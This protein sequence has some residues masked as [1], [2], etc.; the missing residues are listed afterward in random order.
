MTIEWSQPKLPE[1]FPTVEE[2]KAYAATNSHLHDVPADTLAELYKYRKETFPEALF[3]IRNQ[4]LTEVKESYTHKEV[5]TILD[6]TMTSV[7]NLLQPHRGDTPFDE[8]FR[9][10]NVVNCPFAQD[11]QT[12]IDRNEATIGFNAMD[13]WKLVN[14]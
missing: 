6:S 1:L 2:F 10:K 12:V 9:V 3:A 7:I 4:H 13:Y 14:G 8:K 5:Q 11:G